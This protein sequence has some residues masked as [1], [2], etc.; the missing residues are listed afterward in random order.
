[1]FEV[2]ISTKDQLTEETGLN[3]HFVSV[4]MKEWNL[5]IR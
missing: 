3:R 5:S 4:K 1:M 2:N